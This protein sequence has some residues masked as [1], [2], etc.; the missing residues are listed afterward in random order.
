[1]KNLT[2]RTLSTTVLTACLSVA[3]HASDVSN[4]IEEVNAQFENGFA[5]SDAQML[6]DI[7]SDDGQ[8]LPPN[9]PMISGR[10]DILAFWQGALDMKI[11]GAELDTIELDELG[12]TAIEV[13]V[14]KLMGEESQVVDEGKYLVIWKKI[15]DKWKYHRDMWSSSI[16]PN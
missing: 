13:G 8:L 5:Q 3:A 14:Y 1:M 4:A 7:Y 10:D 16:V 6:A 12:N 2:M 11:S 9:G 15:S